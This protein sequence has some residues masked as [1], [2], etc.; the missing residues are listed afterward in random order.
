M[1]AATQPMRRPKRARLPYPPPE[2]ETHCM[3]ADLLR[4]AIKPGWIWWHTPNG[5]LRNKAAAGRLKRM[6]VKPGVSDFLLLSP[7]GD[8]FALELKRE[9]KSPTSDQHDFLAAVFDAGHRSDWVD[10]FDDAVDVLR[11]WGCLRMSHDI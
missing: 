4:L 5:E 2:N 11:R 1:T 9:G 10:T 7:S 8:F 3:I 6:G